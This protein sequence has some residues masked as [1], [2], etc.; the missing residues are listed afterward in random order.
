MTWVSRRVFVPLVAVVTAV[1]C[2]SMLTACARTS[3]ASDAVGTSGHTDAFVVV[4]TSAPP[5]ITVE[6][7]TAEPLIDVNVSIKSGMLTFTDR[8]TRLEA[9]EKRPIRHGDF[10]SRDGTSFNLRIARP[11]EVNVSA[12]SLDGKAFEATTPWQ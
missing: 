6:N 4:D 10:T 9:N 1:A 2:G 12:K 7:R 5:V 11:R 3:S 8:V